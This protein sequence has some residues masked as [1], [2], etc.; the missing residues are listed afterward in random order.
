MYRFSTANFLTAKGAAIASGHASDPH[1]IDEQIK[2]YGSKYVET[3]KQVSYQIQSD[4]LSKQSSSTI[5]DFHLILYDEFGIRLG[6]L[7]KA[8]LT[9]RNTLASHGRENLTLL[10]LDATRTAYLATLELAVNHVKQYLSY[11]GY[12][13]SF[14]FRTN[15]YHKRIEFGDEISQDPYLK[16]LEDFSVFTLFMTISWADEKDSN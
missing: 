3:L 9:L 8:L 1:P 5:G 15:E 14:L 2:E 7:Y 4:I 10:A 16:K 13:V 6:S 12:K 11:H